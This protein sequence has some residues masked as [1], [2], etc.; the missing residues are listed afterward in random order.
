MQFDSA[1]FVA[2]FAITFCLYWSVKSASRQNL[3]LL[4]ASYVFYGAWSWKF[5]ALLLATTAIDYYA[6]LLIAKSDVQPRRRMILA[7]S[8]VINLSLLAIAKYFGFFIA[9]TTAL[10]R[11]FG[12]QPHAEILRIAVPAGISFYT[13]QSMGYVLDVYRR[14]Q[15]AT[16]N[17]LDHALFVAFFPQLVA[18]PIERASRQLP[19]LQSLRKW[20]RESFEDGLQ[21][22][23][24]GLFKKVFIADNLASY[25]NAVYTQP[26]DFSGGVLLTA[27]IFFAVQIYCELSG[28]VDL[29]RGLARMLGVELSTNFRHPY[30]SR[31]PLQFWARWQITLMQWFDD[32]VRAPFEQRFVRNDGRAAK[33]IA[34]LISMSLIGLWQGANITFVMFGIYWGLVI[35]LYLVVTDRHGTKE[36]AA[37]TNERRERSLIATGG[38]WFSIWV[39]FVII[40]LGWILFRADS[41]NQAWYVVSHLLARSGVSEVLRPEVLKESALWCL[42][43]GLWIIELL[44]RNATVLVGALVG[45]EWRRLLWRHLMLVTIMGSYFIFQDPRARTLIEFQ[46]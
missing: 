30:F 38:Y 42:V 26:S 29:A 3:L 33:Y 24:W 13:L 45:S 41:P 14:K 18:G 11:E 16:R 19:Q 31:N 9:E 46:F 44:Q 7:I 35:A 15:P 25:V 12:L 21:L 17:P 39:M 20:R 37:E 8:I 4:V 6:A 23:I 2:F 27:S 36:A 40:C 10:L 1:I 5:L 34:Y 32:Y 22:A 28:Y 43:G